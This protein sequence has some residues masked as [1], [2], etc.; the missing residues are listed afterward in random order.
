[1]EEI[2]SQIAASP[3]ALVVG[4]IVGFAAAKLTGRRKRGGM[5]GF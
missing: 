2:I 3:E 5:G 1:M 4:I